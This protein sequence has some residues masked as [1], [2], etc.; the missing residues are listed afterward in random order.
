M[1]F[2]FWVCIPLIG[3]GDVESRTAYKLEG[4]IGQTFAAAQSDEQLAI[5]LDL[6]LDGHIEA[7]HPPT[8]RALPAPA[9]DLGGQAATAVGKT[10][11]GADIIFGFADGTIR[12][13]QLNLKQIVVADSAIP[14]GGQTLDERD[15]LAGDAVFSRIPG[16]QRRTT[17][18]TSLEPPVQVAAAGNRDPEGRLPRVRVRRSARSRPSSRSTARHDPPQPGRFHR[19]HDDGETSSEVTSSEIPTDVTAADVVALLLNADGTRVIIGLKDGTLLRF[20]TRD[21][22][23]PLLVERARTL[24]EG[25]AL[26]AV[27]YLNGDQSLVIGGSDGSTAIWFGVDRKSQDTKDGIVLTKVHADFDPMPAAITDIREAS[28][29]ACSYGR[30]AGN[31]WVRHATTERTLAELPEPPANGL[32][33]L[34]FSPR[35]R[36]GA[37]HRPHRRHRA[38]GAS[39]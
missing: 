8:G 19:Q 15:V 27:N 30:R 12:L 7:F 13:G 33:G 31:V 34:V 24:P 29:P 28:A 23:N 5:A 18:E 3:G 39:T 21:F 11:Q 20:N 25:V 37:R 6:G 10:L 38:S 4:H 1:A 16:Q 22:K 17:I 36:R 14:A 9:F 32:S 2:L 26:S 35:R